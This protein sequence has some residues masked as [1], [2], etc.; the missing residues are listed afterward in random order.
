MLASVPWAAGSSTGPSGEASTA[1]DWCLINLGHFTT[2]PGGG[3][4]VPFPGQG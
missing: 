2:S 4:P 3:A 1:A